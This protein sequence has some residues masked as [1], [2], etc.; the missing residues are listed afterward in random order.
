MGYNLIMRLKE[1]LK[2]N[3]KNKVNI[4]KVR[5]WLS[6]GQVASVDAEVSTLK[7]VSRLS[8]RLDGVVSSISLLHQGRVLQ[9]DWTK[10]DISRQ[11]NWTIRDVNYTGF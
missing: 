7:E 11:K 4:M 10:G 3:N 2:T 1:T 6:G 5:F 9:W 8:R